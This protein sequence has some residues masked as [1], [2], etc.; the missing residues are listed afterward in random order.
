MTGY[1][2]DENV[3]PALRTAIHHQWPDVAVWIIGDPSA[4]KRGTPDP[5]ILT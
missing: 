5:D 2:L 4:P 1:L 3:D